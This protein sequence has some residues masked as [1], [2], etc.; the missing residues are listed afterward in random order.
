MRTLLLLIL[1]LVAP[2]LAAAT[3]TPATTP[4][5][6]SSTRDH[7]VILL[8]GMWRTE[9]SMLAVKWK[10]EEAGYTVA[11]VTYP[12]LTYPIEELAEIAIGEGLE[13]CRAQSLQRINFV[14]HSLGGILLRQY[15]S[16]HSIEGLQRAVMLGPPNQGSQ[17]AH[18][19]ESIDLLRPFTPTPLPQLGTG[20]ESLPRQLGPV[21]F[22]LGVIA[23][24]IS[25]RP[26]LPGFPAE[27]S[28]GTVA[29]EETRVAGMVDFIEIGATHSFIMWNSGVLEQV[30][31]FLQHGHFDHDSLADPA[32]REFPHGPRAR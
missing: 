2:A 15:L 29:V 11:S 14:T 32:P 30:V 31:Y 10:L 24:N 17:L 5:L 27:P 12:S 8:H 26:P 13:E 23:G 1:G 22:E 20:E 6:A 25:I 4:A 3:P 9:L 7:C 18:Y 19:I 28:D 21:D 16:R